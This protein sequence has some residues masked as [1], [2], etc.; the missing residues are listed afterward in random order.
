MLTVSIPTGLMSRQISPHRI[1]KVVR[2]AQERV[3]KTA[4][5][6]ETEATEK[7]DDPKYMG[8]IDSFVD[9]YL[10]GDAKKSAL[11]NLYDMSLNTA[12]LEQE[13][14]KDEVTLN[15]SRV[16]LY[17]RQINENK[18]RLRILTAGK[19]IEFGEKG[20]SPILGQD[21][22]LIVRET[23]RI[24]PSGIELSQLKSKAPTRN[25]TPAG[26]PT[27][28]NPEQITHKDLKLL[29]TKGAFVCGSKTYAVRFTDENEPVLMADS[30]NSLASQ[31][32][33]RL[34]ALWINDEARRELEDLDAVRLGG[35]N[36]LNLKPGFLDSWDDGAR[37]NAQLYLDK[38][39]EPTAKTINQKYLTTVERI[40]APIIEEYVTLRSEIAHLAENSNPSPADRIRLFELQS[41]STHLLK[42]LNAANLNIA[43]INVQFERMI[44]ILAQCK[45]MTMV[46]ILTKRI[47]LFSAHICK[48]SESYGEGQDMPELNTLWRIQEGFLDHFNASQ[49]R[50]CEQILNSPMNELAQKNSQ[51]APDLPVP[52]KGLVDCLRD[53]FVPWDQVHSQIQTCHDQ[54]LELDTNR[55]KQIN[56]F[57]RL[58]AI[59]QNLIDFAEAPNRPGECPKTYFQPVTYT[60]FVYLI[61]M[62]NALQD[63]RNIFSRQELE[64]MQDAIYSN[65]QPI[66]LE[67]SQLEKQKEK[68]SFFRSLKTFDILL[69]PDRTL[70]DY[71]EWYLTQSSEDRSIP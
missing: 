20:Y 21:G 35:I 32:Q 5:T 44:A 19:S 14:G 50:Q 42:R 39:W 62:R 70:M 17:I 2:A 24:S 18:A 63:G 7:A 36:T 34:S 16:E 31:I 27:F 26:L 55:S 45:D 30:S 25:P 46:D 3:A 71:K 51:R 61:K 40:R 58:N 1:S 60:H 56:I 52:T 15:H 47:A 38:T 66:L 37:K 69:N 65:L 43:R 22:Y 4:T 53:P 13:L 11:D 28:M 49:L 29:S 57:V 41:L 6:E 48:I 68:L 8:P 12:L 23:G 54:Q 67:K 59:L 9:H 33:A 10:C 64:E